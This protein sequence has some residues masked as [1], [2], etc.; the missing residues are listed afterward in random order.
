MR[1]YL[2][3]IIVVLL[4]M[5]CATYDRPIAP[6]EIRTYEK[7]LEVPNTSKDEI[8]VKANEWFVHTFNSAESVIQFQDKEAG[9]IMGKYRFNIVVGHPVSINPGMKST[10]SVDVKVNRAKILI[11]GL[12]SDFGADISNDLE[13]VEEARKVWVKLA[14][15]LEEYLNQKSEW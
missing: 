11:Q 13:F 10:I 5:S 9:K 4:F 12:I 7:I 3:P 2:I 14:I 6:E 15:S 8:Y 1:K